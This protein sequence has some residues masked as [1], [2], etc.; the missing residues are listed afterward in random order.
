MKKRMVIMLVSVAIVLSVIGFV[1][2]NQIRAAIAEHASFALPPEAITTIAAAVDTWPVKLSAIGSVKAAQGVVVSA[3][4][5]GIVASIEFKSGARVKAGDV[6]VRLDTKQEAAQLAAAEAQEHLAMV[7]H[8]RLTTLRAQGVVAQAEFDQS[9]AETKQAEARVKEVKATI[10]RKTIR[11]PFS[12]DL[13]IRQVDLGQYVT[14]GQPVV[15]LQSLDPAYADFSVP[16]Q[17]VHSV[18]VGA[19]L[20]ISVEGVPGVAAKGKIIAI[21]SLIDQS[22][23]NANVRAEFPNHAGKL[24]PGMFVDVS[25]VVGEGSKLVTLPSSAISHAPYGDFVF[26]VGDLKNPVSGQTYKGVTQQAVKLGGERG[27][28]VAILEGLKPGEVVATSG[29][30]KLRSGASVMVSNDVQPGN[31]PKPQPEDN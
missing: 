17:D 23:R 19:E 5:P 8:E 10:E 27:D 18:R 26:V 20:D 29:V 4:L 11:A 21:N 28:Q 9:E 1:K 31:N 15:P 16:Q 24:L 2:Y 22:T 25:V 30:F 3:D 13:G 6:L 12:G 7:N 14:A